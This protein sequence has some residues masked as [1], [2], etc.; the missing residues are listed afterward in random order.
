[1]QLIFAKG[2]KNIKWSKNNPSINGIGRAVWTSTCKKMKLDHLL[3]P[4]TKINWRWIKDLNISPDN[5]KN[6]WGKH[7]QKISDIPLSNIFTY[8][9]PKARDVKER[10]NKWDLIKW[11]SSEQLKK[12]SAKWKWNQPYGKTYLPMIPWTKV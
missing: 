8:A 1:M 10:I 11:K 2:G 6:P 5:Y 3:T 9:S 7:R 12:T 4:Y